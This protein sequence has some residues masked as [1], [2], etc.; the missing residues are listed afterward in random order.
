ML[1]PSTDLQG[2]DEVTIH[3]KT[4]RFC[5]GCFEKGTQS[6]RALVFVLVSGLILKIHT[7]YLKGG[8]M[9]TC[10]LCLPKG[11]LTPEYF[12]SSIPLFSCEIL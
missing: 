1:T 2:E 4:G 5:S 3:Q 10:E 9:V 12:L 7:L 11:F 8:M 6:L